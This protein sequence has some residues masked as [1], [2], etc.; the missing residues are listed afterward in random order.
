MTKLSRR[1]MSLRLI[2]RNTITGGHLRGEQTPEDRTMRQATPVGFS[3]PRVFGITASRLER[4]AMRAL[5]PRSHVVVRVPAGW[6]CGP[7]EGESARSV[8]DTDR[9][10]GAT[11]VWRQ[12]CGTTECCCPRHR[13]GRHPLESA[14]QWRSSGER[15]LIL[16]EQS[17]QPHSL[18]G[19]RT[20][21]RI[22]T[23]SKNG[24]LLSLENDLDMKARGETLFVAGTLRPNLTYREIDSTLL[25]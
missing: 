18:R 9:S 8:F 20:H 7:Y 13:R 25:P 2:S 1:Y 14:A 12:T 4:A 15:R 10:D 22:P 17:R 19:L 16:S 5:R 21:R 24:A 6:S 3:T 11:R 23:S